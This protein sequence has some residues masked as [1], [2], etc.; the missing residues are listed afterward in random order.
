MN[1]TPKLGPLSIFQVLQTKRRP[2]ICVAVRDEGGAL[3]G[4]PVCVTFARDISVQAGLEW[5]L[6]RLR[7]RRERCPEKSF[8]SFSQAD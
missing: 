4:D 1:G 2:K 8:S 7:S 3:Y 5:V 6:G